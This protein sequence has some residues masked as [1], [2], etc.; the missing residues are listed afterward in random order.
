MAQI[1]FVTEVSGTVSFTFFLGLTLT[2]LPNPF[3]HHFSVHLVVTVDTTSS[4]SSIPLQ[5]RIV[6]RPT[7]FAANL[8]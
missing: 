7:Y 6:G 3:S 5:I 8:K 4:R 2:L 1:L